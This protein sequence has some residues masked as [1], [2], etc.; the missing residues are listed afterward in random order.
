[1][2]YYQRYAILVD[3]SLHDPASLARVS[4]PVKNGHAVPLS[5]LGTVRTGVSPA[6]AQTSYNG[7]HAVILNAFALPGADVVSLGAELKARLA[8][9]VPTLPSV[10][11]FAP[12]W[13]QTTF[14]VESQKALR[15]AIMI[16]ALL[17]IVV[18]Y[19]FL[20]NFRLTLVAAAV[21][22]LAMAIAIFVL[23]QAGQT[24]NLM[25]VGGLAVAVGLIIDDAIVVIENI[26]RTMQEHP[27]LEP[28]AA[29]ERAMGQISTAMIAATTTTVVVFV[30]LALLTGVTGFFFR[31]LASTMAA[32]LIVSLG[33][34]LFVAPISAKVLLRGHKE[35]EHRDA[36]AAVLERY[37]GVLRWALSHRGI[38]AIGSVAVLVVT[39]FLLGRLPSDFLPKT[40]EGKFEIAYLLPVGTTLEASDAAAGSMERILTSDPAVVSVGRLT[41][42]DTNGFS[43][44]PQ[45]VGLMRV[46]LVDPSKRPD[47]DSVSARLR[48]RLQS[49]IPSA[50]YNFHQILED[51]INGL[52]G[53][54]SPIELD[55]RG[56]DQQTL[57]AL[58]GRIT[59]AIAGVPGLVDLNN[60]VTYDNPSL[61]VAPDVTRLAALGLTTQDVGDALAARSQGTIAT[62]VPESARVIPVRVRVAGTDSPLSG[63]TGL[64]A[65]GIPSALGEVTRLNTVRL[66][67]NLDA[68]N[69]QLLL[70]VTGNVGNGSLSSIVDGIDRRLASVPLPPGYSVAI[71]GQA[72]SQAESFNQFLA[73]VSIAIA[74]V[75]AVMLATFRSFRLPLVILTAIPLALIGVALAL[76]LTGTP[77]NVSSFMGLLL[78][79][80][81][82]VKNGILLIDVANQRREQ[83]ASVEESLLAAGKT[84]L[85]PI[86]M[87]TLAAIGGLIPLALGIGQGAELEKPL[88]IA[89]IGGLSTATFFTLIL[90]PVLYATFVGGA[91]ARERR[92]AERMATA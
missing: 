54:T 38:V 34:A 89:V 73:V 41:A 57:I 56:A 66:S 59:K 50:S 58:A 80:G 75:F 6:T 19:A 67:S 51:Q 71:G 10:V 3:A 43:P 49:A 83:G 69:G 18:I 4:V 72:R 84:R 88:A 87:T 48:D 25:S 63:S 32:S 29:I 36:I 16:G 23:Q 85:R 91:E 20:R 65:K 90:I 1:Q 17:A 45:N 78:L 12:Y 53:S 31:A 52:Q 82:V 24:L 30:P 44:T 61:R 13:D 8:T 47:Y 21:V 86:V 79:V 14:I 26:A 22:P 2:R 28:P 27:E 46:T 40:D 74:L 33:L 76:T 92:A 70:R 77:F 5:A 42:V 9:I 64:L 55:V 11:K 37:D 39:V 15:D 62:S 60:G 7:Q 35:H 68:E 81:I